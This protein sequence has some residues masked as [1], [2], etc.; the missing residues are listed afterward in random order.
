LVKSFKQNCLAKTLKQIK[1]TKQN[2]ADLTTNC[3]TK[4]NQ[5]K[6][7]ATEIIFWLSFSNNII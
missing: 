4:D 5:S 6:T 1:Q 3:K 7:G 2:L